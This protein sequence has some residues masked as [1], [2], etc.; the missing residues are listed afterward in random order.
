MVLVC[1]LAGCRPGP[2]GI[3]VD[4]DDV[5]LCV[6]WMWMGR[7]L[8][9]P[10]PAAQASSLDAVPLLAA[11]AGYVS[12]WPATRA[13]TWPV[14]RLLAQMPDAAL[15]ALSP[16][17]PSVSGQGPEPPSRRS[18][19]PTSVQ[20]PPDM[21]PETLTSARPGRP[22]VYHQ[23]DQTTPKHQQGRR[24]RCF[25]PWY[26]SRPLQYTHN[27]GGFGFLTMYFNQS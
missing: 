22:S 6:R 14:R 1:A 11:P 13:L 9:N 19:T 5:R 23:S 3:G 10:W 16:K 20:S 24:R 26:R 21:I 17:R 7:N 4:V 15:H 18:T 2:V 12:R 25:C 27:K 8:V